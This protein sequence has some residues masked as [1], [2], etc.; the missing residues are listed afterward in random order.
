MREKFAISP[1]GFQPEV[2]PLVVRAVEALLA[3]RT[4]SD[5]PRLEGEALQH[6]VYNACHGMWRAAAS[7]RPTALVLDDLHWADPAS[8]DLMV[9]LF[10][11]VDEVPLLLICSFRPERQSPAWRMKQTAEVDYP[12]L[13]TEIPLQALSVEDSETLF[14]NLLNITD[15]P[16]Q[17]RQ[18]ILE[19]TPGNPFFMEEFIRTL[20]DT[21]AV[22]RDDSGMRWCVDAKVEDIPIP[23]NLQALLS[24]R[25]DRLED[26]ARRTLQLSSVIGRSFHYGVINLISGS[27]IDLDR[28]LSTLQR[29][30]LIRESSRVPELEYIFQHDLT[31]EAAYNSI[32]LRERREFHKRVG[33]AV[34]E[35]FNDRLEEQSHLLAH[36]FYEAGETQRALKYSIIAGER[37]LSTYAHEEA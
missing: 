15:S 31:R 19:K 35:M 3:F 9:D 33:E 32:L 26:D 13:Y 10:S 5:I 17:L 22:I 30:E 18:M 8:V 37:A 4:D 7:F 11:L 36:H 21:G 20:I 34:E 6:E 23:E 2:I 28:Q 24:A 1:E 16:A 12:H 25:I 14:G 29:V 27:S